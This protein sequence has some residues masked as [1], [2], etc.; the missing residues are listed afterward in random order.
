TISILGTDDYSDVTVA[1]Y[2]P[3]YLDTTLVRINQEYPHIGV[4][5][6]QETEFDHR[7]QFPVSY[8]Q[9]DAAG[10]YQLI[11]IKPGKYNLAF[12]KEGVSLKYVYEISLSEGKNSLQRI[13]LKPSIDI[14][15]PI[16]EPIVFESGVQY[17]FKQNTQILSPAIVEAGAILA[18]D[19]QKK[20]EFFN[21]LN[22]TIEGYFKLT[23]AY[24]VNNITQNE[25]EDLHFFNNISVYGNESVD[26]HNIIISF[27]KD[28]ISSISPK[29][30]ISNIVIDQNMC[31][32][33]IKGGEIILENILNK[34]ST[35]TSICVANGTQYPINY[36]YARNNISYNNNMNFDVMQMSSN[37]I[38]NYFHKNDLSLK[39][40]IVPN[41]RLENNFFFNNKKNIDMYQ[42]KI[43]ISK[44]SF[45]KNNIRDIHFTYG[46]K[47]S[48]LSNNFYEKENL[49]IYIQ[50][51]DRYEQP[52]NNKI[53]ATNNFFINDDI[54]N[55][56]YDIYDDIYC[57]YE[58]QYI[59]RSLTPIRDA[60][61][62]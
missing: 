5:I 51:D 62:Q 10:N 39:Y 52:I 8:A 37:I 16:T 17:N 50:P 34:N 19:P 31:A 18:I 59:P 12:L 6:S 7:L 24:S 21:N 46:S 13:E 14:S 20:L 49:Y 54:S 22:C 11:N 61:I 32:I 25:M 2:T 42:S 28:G 30:Q 53:D 45:L 43:Y 36:F 57:H 56:I 41:S 4:I 15:T 58:V 27:I 3:A 55:Q 23:S 35:V 47:I 29:T 9:T 60:G 44:N 48:I 38:N 26:L 33:D 1:L 40:Y